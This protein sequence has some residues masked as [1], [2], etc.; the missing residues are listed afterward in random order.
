MELTT[1][2]LGEIAKIIN[3]ATP[4]TA[5]SSNYDGKIVWITPK[6]LSDQKSKYISKGA[7]NITQKGYDGCST[8]MIP[9]NNILM[10]SRAPIG[11]L[12][13][14]AVDC[15]TNQGFKNI[16]VDKS[17]CDVNYLYYY[18]KFHIAE[19]EALGSG[20]TFKEVSKAS[21]QKFELS[22]PSMEEQKR[23][24]Q[25]LSDL[26]DKIILNRS[27]N[28]NLPLPGRS[29]GAAEERRAA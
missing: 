6:D 11:L 16:V 9:A 1:Y 8:Q 10:S 2:K 4:S 28:H 14:N 3:G 7:R 27:I 13:I 18:L 24:G 15:C 19:V 23:I 20:T 12:S 22:I 21:L 26:D 25:T 5:D 17:K 29:L